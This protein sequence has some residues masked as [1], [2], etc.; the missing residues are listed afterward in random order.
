M[1]ISGD[2]LRRAPRDRDDRLS[3]N[4]ES[5]HM[6]LPR[7]ALMSYGGDCPA[8]YSQDLISACVHD[9]VSVDCGGRDGAHARAAE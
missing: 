8:R 1:N 5:F 2:D 4:D 9:G 7:A 3:A 6:D